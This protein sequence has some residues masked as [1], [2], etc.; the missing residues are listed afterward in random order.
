MKILVTGASGFI[1]GHVVAE[2][3]RRGH[4]A[5]ALLR[6]PGP[7]AG[8]GRPGLETLVWDLSS[9]AGRPDLDGMAVD[10]VVHLA[11]ALAGSREEQHATTVQ[12]TVHLLDAMRAAGIRRL[13]GV[14]SIAVL[15]YVT[16][17]PMS[18]I[19]ESN[20]LP[21][22]ERGMGIYAALKAKQEVLFRA[23]AAEPGNHCVIL[24][25][26]LVFDDMWLINAH[27]GIVK[28]P[29][30]MLAK[31]EGEVPVVAVACMA[32]AAVD[33]VERTLPGGEVIHLV[34][35]ALPDQQA[36]LAGLRRRGLLPAGGIVVPWRLMAG[37]VALLR[38][39]ARALGFGG[40]L[41]EVFLPQSFAAR[42]KPFRYSNAKARRL[43]GWIPAREFS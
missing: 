15:D 10:A 29:L 13:V 23:F 17:T 19:D 40:K 18:V 42:M 41:P 24:R 43:L 22:E 34:D 32:R 37:L 8:E 38:G 12:G 26:G 2:I 36:Y 39:T 3:L 16:P 14:S 11:A 25:P 6:T 21:D 35:D 7:P 31:H 30:R 4:Q 27:A 9:A 20:P 1:G 5:V 33:C 28:G